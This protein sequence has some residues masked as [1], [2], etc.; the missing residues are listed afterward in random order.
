VPE[1]GAI[2]R[3]SWGVGSNMVC[4]RR[5]AAAAAAGFATA[6][7]LTVHIEGL[8]DAVGVLL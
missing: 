6:S 3:L 8:A 5:G 1:H 4:S 7:M 2:C